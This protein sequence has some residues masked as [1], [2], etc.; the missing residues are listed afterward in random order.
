MPEQTALPLHRRIYDDLNG[1]IARGEYGPGDRLPT[2]LDLA[3]KFATSRTTIIRALRDLAHNGVIER[4]QG[5]GS[6]VRKGPEKKRVSLAYCPF[7]VHSASELPYVE[8]LIHHHLA[9]IAG[10]ND[11]QL[12]FECLG[13]EQG[14]A[15]DQMIS[16]AERLIRRRVNG[17]LYYPAELEPG[18][19]DAN[20]EAV[21]LL[22]AAGTTVVLVDRDLVEYPG[23]SE[24]TR[25]GYDNRRGSILLTDHLVRVGAR[26]IAFIGIP[27]VSTA[28][29]ERLAGYYE[30]LRYHKIL[31]KPD[32][33]Q[34]TD[35][36][37]EDF[38]R[39]LMDRVKPDAILCKSDRFAAIVGRHLTSLGIK[40]GVDVR[41]AG[42]DDDPIAAHL[43]V[44]L[45][46]VRLPA[47]PFAEAA[48][49]ALMRRLSSADH[50][51]PRQIIIDTELVVRE[52]T[53]GF[54]E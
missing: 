49:D 13:M 29:H 23:R 40:I 39:Q 14:S 15:R 45:T 53:T 41:L 9:V 44:P 26:K 37:S 21:N 4:R 34:L 18:E 47:R 38:C 22:T 24:F 50:T 8:G 33:I 46:T 11:L 19:M 3:E 36:L 32:W 27:Q 16:A 25:I 52:S 31:P 7:F 48:F 28:V 12:D 42:F 54:T 51:G 35:D 2:E 20:R 5:S 43:P 6:Y 30:G 17:V 10:R 1:S